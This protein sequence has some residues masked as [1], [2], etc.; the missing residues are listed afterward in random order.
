[1][2]A[3]LCRSPKENNA[4]AS[5]HQT[6]SKNEIQQQHPE[7]ELTTI[8]KPI[9][10]DHKDY[11]L[12]TSI[13]NGLLDSLTSNASFLDNLSDPDPKQRS[14]SVIEQ[15]AE[16][17][18]HKMN[19]HH[20]GQSKNEIFTEFA[21]EIFS[22]LRTSFNISDDEYLSN[23][24]G[25]NNAL[26][27]F[28]SNSKSGQYF[29]FSNNSQFIIKTMSKS[30]LHFL[31]QLLPSYYEHMCANEHSLLP[32]FYGVYKL[33]NIKLHNRSKQNKDLAFLI[34]NN[35][36][37]SPRNI[38]ITQ[39]YDLKGSRQGRKTDEI[40]KENG[41]I[42]K[43]LNFIEDDVHLYISKNDKDKMF[44]QQIK[45]DTDWFVKHQIMDYS[46]LV[47]IAQ[48]L[49][50]TNE[51]EM[52]CVKIND[53]AIVSNDGTAI[54][55]LG[56]IDILQKYN[57]KKKVAGFVKGIKHEKSTLSTVPPDQ[58]AQ[59]FCNFFADRVH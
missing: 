7:T 49:D 58:Y 22:Q 57:K 2:G 5:A 1:M 42:L 56:I 54:Y 43:D 9:T 12:A 17:T 29:F 6:A 21:P 59:R 53:G 33:N 20:D 51:D 3:C 47:G 38:P 55:F 18:E 46:L 23:L 30:E 10:S 8:M 32:K 11:N 27:S 19:A 25:D 48:N 36:F 34:S 31:L 40:Q 35:V 26:L 16:K 45:A 37:Y 41:D 52:E 4:D 13:Q 28:L 50:N 39:Q 24:T 44:Y 15:S 14:K